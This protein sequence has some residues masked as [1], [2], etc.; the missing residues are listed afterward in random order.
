MLQNGHTHSEIQLASDQ[1]AK[2][3]QQRLETIQEIRQKVK[4]I[5]AAGKANPNARKLQSTS[6]MPLSRSQQL[7]PSPIIP[8]RSPMRVAQWNSARFPHLQ[9]PQGRDTDSV[10]SPRCSTGRQKRP[11]PI[12]LGDDLFDGGDALTSDIYNS[13]PKRL[14]SPA[15]GNE[16]SKLSPRS[17]TFCSSMRFPARVKSPMADSRP[18][19]MP[20]RIASPPP[21]MLFQRSSQHPRTM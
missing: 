8:R 13:T 15:G 16:K 20:R 3:R 11:A 6:P 10:V 5:L 2:T 4:A 7:P 12:D 19:L 21:S 18:L 9:F 17:S 1:A 14:R